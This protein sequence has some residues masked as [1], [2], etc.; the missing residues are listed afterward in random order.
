[1]SKLWKI[2]S[3]YRSMSGR[4]AKSRGV[5]RVQLPG[6]TPSSLLVA[7]LARTGGI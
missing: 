4:I 3:D 7:L 5:A 2:S 1:M 6:A